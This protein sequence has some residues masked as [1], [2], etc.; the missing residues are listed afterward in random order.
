M[1]MPMATTATALMRR[2]CAGVSAN[3]PKN[4]PVSK[5]TSMA[6]RIGPAT[7]YMAQPA[8]TQN[9][10]CSWVSDGSAL[11]RRFQPLRIAP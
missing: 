11:N 10:P 5:V 4:W 7:T 9:H 1:V 3:T 2:A 8:S 6:P